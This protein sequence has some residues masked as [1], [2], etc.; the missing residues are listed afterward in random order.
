MDNLEKVDTSL[1]TQFSKNE[2]GKKQNLKIPVTSKKLESV[3]KKTPKNK[4]PGTDGFTEIYET[5]KE[6]IISILK[7]FQKVDFINH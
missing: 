6:E 2:P 5:C 3:I 7:E 1:E 4:S